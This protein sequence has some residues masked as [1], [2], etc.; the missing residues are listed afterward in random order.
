MEQKPLKYK[1]LD[2]ISERQLSE[3]HD[4]LY[5]GYVTKYNEINE[6]LKTVDL[7][8]ANA[9]YSELRE[10]TIE[11]GFALNGVKLHE[12][13]FDGLGGKGG[14]P[15]GPIAELII[16]DFG[17]FEAW[18]EQ[19]KALGM[20]ARGWVVL[21]YN[22]D[23]QKLENYICDVHNQGGIWNTSTVLVMDV[24]EHSYFIDYGVKRVDYIDKYMANIDWEEVNNRVR[25]NIPG[26]QEE[27]TNTQKGE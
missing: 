9:T 10:L 3:H 13:Y 5:A 6:S 15:N 27:N 1:S 12:Y 14:E 21:A 24:Y 26:Y 19:F 11:K 4:V 18:N 23:L 22:Y 8:V 20:S 2:G 7:K 16:R 17:S 25:N